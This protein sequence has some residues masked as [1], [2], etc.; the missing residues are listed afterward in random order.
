MYTRNRISERNQFFQ[1][2]FLDYSCV[3]KEKN[4]VELRKKNRQTVAKQK[5]F[6]D[7]KMTDLINLI[8]EELSKV[9]PQLSLT[10]IPLTEKLNNIESLLLNLNDPVLLTQIINFLRQLVQ[11]EDFA[12]YFISRDCL[13]QHLISLLSNLNPVIKYDIA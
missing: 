11:A 3:L 2:N 12:V 13:I 4:S 10:S 7:S 6:H 5:R 1:K 8:P 9:M